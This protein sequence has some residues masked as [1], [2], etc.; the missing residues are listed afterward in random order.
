M[1][2]PGMLGGSQR[3]ALH[4]R[5]GHAL[6]VR[7]TALVGCG[8]GQGLPVTPAAAARWARRRQ[9]FVDPKS[10]DRGAESLAVDAISIAPGARLPA[11][12]EREAAPVPA[13]AGVRRDDLHRLPPP[14]PHAREQDPDETIHAPQGADAWAPVGAGPPTGGAARGPRRSV[15][16]ATGWWSERRRRRTRAWRLAGAPS[17]VRECNKISAFGVFS[18]DTCSVERPARPTHPI[19]ARSPDLC[20]PRGGPAG[21]SPAAPRLPTRPIRRHRSAGPSGRSR[22]AWMPAAA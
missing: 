1:S 14:T 15:R 9:D 4:P 16:D 5:P 19:S 21:R 20:A 13:H 8:H 2:A 3:A 18:R 7:R 10:I 22:T 11:P 12:V 17:G 6:R